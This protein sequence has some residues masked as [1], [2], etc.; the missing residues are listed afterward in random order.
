MKIIEC[1]PNFSEGRDRKKIAAIAHVFKSFPGV[2]LADFSSDTDHNRSVFTFLGK[3]EDVLEAALA[4]CGKAVKLIDMREQAGVHPRLGAVDVVPFIPL[5]KAKMKDAVDLAHT[6]GRQLYE[7]FGVPVYFYGHA[8]MVSGRNE[9][10]D[11]RH[12]GYEALQSKMI[13]PEDAPDIGNP[14]F[15]A[16]AGATVVGAREP[17]VAFNIDLNSNDLRLVR[18][19]ASQIREKNGG[20][21][22]VRAIGVILKNRGVAQ[23]SINLTNCKETPFK[24]IYD[25]VEELAAKRGVQ[26]LESELIGLVPKCA[27]AGT[28][29]D[30][31]KLKDF[32]KNRLLETHLK[33]LED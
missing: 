7:R 23:V 28:K 33:I 11:V 2:R 4:A 25:Q 1:V 20:L 6:F 17:L 10:A 21:K 24:V 12:G 32:D 15:N 18:N 22:H 30:Y 29:P 26:I 31:L 3:P 16:R 13:N 14:E 9:L 19:I 5:G 8:A 27:F